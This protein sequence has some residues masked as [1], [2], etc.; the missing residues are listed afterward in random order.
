MMHPPEQIATTRLLLRKPLMEDADAIFREYAGDPE[1]TKYLTWK[2]D[3]ESSQAADYIR[4]AL[5]DWQEGRIFSWAICLQGSGG[6]VGM[7][8]ARVDG[9]MVNIGYVLG[10]AHWNKGYATE[11]LSAVLHWTDA[12]EDV[13]RVWAVCAVENLAS[14][15]VMEKAGMK[16]EGTL[17]HWMVFPNLSGVPMDCYCYAHVK[18]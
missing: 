2:T 18:G 14:A 13:Q 9:Y 4:K 11:A 8:D 3:E 5:R 10:R 17:R 1:A 7:I 16:R 12:E 15:R 6:V